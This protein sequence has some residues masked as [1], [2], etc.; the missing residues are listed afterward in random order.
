MPPQRVRA[1]LERH[2]PRK[3]DSPPAFPVL[4]PSCGSGVF[5]VGAWQR[6]VE[7][8]NQI[9]PD[10]SPEVLKRLMQQNIHGVDVERDSVELTIF[11]L[12]VAL[13]S[14]FPYKA[15]EPDFTF[16]QLKKLK[17]PN[18]KSD[19]KLRRNVHCRDFF[20]ERRALVQDPLRFQLIIGN[21][22]F[23]S[24]LSPDAQE[25]FDSTALDEAGK[26]WEPVPDRNIS[27]LFLRAV[28]PLLDQGGTACLVQ[29]ASLPA[30]RDAVGTLGGL[31]ELVREHAQV[32]ATLGSSKGSQS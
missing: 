21:P 7:G 9:D 13:C 16:K 31:A 17:F 30:Q 12:C 19:D 29:N 15:E 10:P 24:K 1:A 8:L 6:L 23:E 27:Y 3:T 32:P 11:S 28:P 5:L 4:D 26:S 20:I 2:D 14:A 25:S 18:L 22:P